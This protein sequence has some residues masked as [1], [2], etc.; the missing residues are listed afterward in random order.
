MAVS[1]RSR[2]RPPRR[3]VVAAQVDAGPRSAPAI[4][5]GTRAASRAACTTASWALVR[6]STAMLDHGRPGVRAIFTRSAAQ[7]ASSSSVAWDT[8][9]GTGPSTRVVRGR[10]TS[11]AAA[12]RA[13]LAQDGGGHR[14]H[15]GRAAVVLVEPDD[16]GAAQNVGQPVEQGGV[17]AVEPVHGLVGVAHDEEVGLVGQHCGQQTGTGPD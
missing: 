13:A 3:P 14:D 16:L 1:L 17:R 6:V 4:R 9:F 2:P 11:P 5:F 15:L 7:A 12:E 8:T 10:T